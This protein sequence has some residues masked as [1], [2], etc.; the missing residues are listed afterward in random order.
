MN[1]WMND[2]FSWQQQQQ[3]EDGCCFL[4]WK[5]LCYYHVIYTPDTHIH[6]QIFKNWIHSI[7]QKKTTNSTQ[8]Y[9]ITRKND[10]TGTEKKKKKNIAKTTTTKIVNDLNSIDKEYIQGH[11]LVS[12]TVVVVLHFVVMFFKSNVKLIIMSNVKDFVVLFF[13]FP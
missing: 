7:Q 6:G 8:S 11:Q 13:L 1:E 5:T 10:G 9:Y 4:G 12:Q 3:N 2:F